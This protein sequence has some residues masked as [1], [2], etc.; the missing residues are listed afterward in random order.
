MPQTVRIVFDEPANAGA[1]PAPKSGFRLCKTARTFLL[2]LVV[3]FVCLLVS[4]VVGALRPSLEYTA[5][6]SDVHLT[7]DPQSF[8]DWLNGVFDFHWQATRRVSG[9]TAAVSAASFSSL[10][11]IL[12]VA[13]GLSAS[14]AAYQAVFNNPM[15]TPDLLGVTSGTILG[16][17]IS[18]YFLG[19]GYYGRVTVGVIFGFLTIAFVLFV[20]QL[21]DRRGTSALTLL[22]VGIVTAQLIGSLLTGIMNGLFQQQT[23]DDASSLY[24]VIYN[25]QN[26]TFIIDPDGIFLVAAISLPAIVLIA[27]LGWRLN[28]LAFGDEE[29]RGIGVDPKNLRRTAL[30]ASTVVTALIGATC[31]QISFVGLVAPHMARKLLGS[32]YKVVIPAAMLLGTIFLL[33]GLFIN[34]IF[35]TSVNVFTSIVGVP[36]FIHIL[37]QQRRSRAARA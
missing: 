7:V 32:N 19:F 18:A 33:I 20:S 35:G 2:L 13:F 25:L 27:L 26:G 16:N 11:I 8:R 12:T 36:Y 28:A 17:I 10:L 15:A 9:Q 34:S 37:L 6:L 14:G 4:I 29:A 1:R 5:K 30:I 22:L 21:I 3:F 23:G 31:G 24:E